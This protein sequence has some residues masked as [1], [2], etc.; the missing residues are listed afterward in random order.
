MAVVGG[1]V[2]KA[3]RRGRRRDQFVFA[4]Q[5][6]LAHIEIAWPA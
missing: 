1:R 4:G 5:R 2:A 3:A 6:W